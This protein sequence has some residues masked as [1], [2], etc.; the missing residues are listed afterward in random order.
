MCLN[1]TSIV[2]VLSLHRSVS[3]LPTWTP[4][5]ASLNHLE[6]ILQQPGAHQDLHDDQLTF[7]IY[8]RDPQPVSRITEDH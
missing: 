2:R 3:A 4:R 1:Q 8:Q 7:E 6:D 5:E